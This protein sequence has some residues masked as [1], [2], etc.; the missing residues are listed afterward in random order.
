MDH[1]VQMTL[2]QCGLRALTVHVAKNLCISFWLPQNL[3]AHSLLLTESLTSNRYSWLTHIFHY[4]CYILYS[5]NTVRENVNRIIRKRKYTVLC[6]IYWK[7]KSMYKWACKVQTHVVQGSTV[8]LT[9]ES[10]YLRTIYFIRLSLS[11]TVIP[12]IDLG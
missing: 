1:G 6:Y 9:F 5:Y 12:W 10:Y 4:T 11:K 2:K 7:K 3:T 8:I